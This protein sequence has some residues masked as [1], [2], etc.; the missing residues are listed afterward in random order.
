MASVSH[1]YIGKSEMF[2]LCIIWIIILYSTYMF[3]E[4]FPKSV[5]DI[6]SAIPLKF[7][8]G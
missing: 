7:G 2:I 4:S 3:S 5:I 1:V 6:R 8:N